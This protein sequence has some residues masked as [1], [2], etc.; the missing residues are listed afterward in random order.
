MSR[1]CL[2][3][4]FLAGVLAVTALPAASAAAASPKVLLV[5]RGEEGEGPPATPGEAAHITNFIEWNEATDGCGG[6]DESS[7]VG[8]N[9]AP[10]VKVSGSDMPLANLQC[11]NSGSGPEPTGSVTIKSVSLAKSGRIT[12][13]GHLELQTDCHYR[14]SKLTGT[15]TFGGEEEVFDQLSGIGKLVKKGSVPGCP[16]T[17]TVQDFMG[18]ADAAGFNYLARLI[19]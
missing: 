13:T 2:T 9:P 12:L 8:A 11:F 14:A 15:Q 7:I 1:R 19:S 18:V 16:A 5:T 4:L 6:T 17:V 3:L 10:T